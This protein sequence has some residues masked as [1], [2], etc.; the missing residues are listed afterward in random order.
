MCGIIN[1]AIIGGWRRPVNHIGQAWKAA[2]L[3]SRTVA[4]AMMDGWWWMLRVTF[5]HCNIKK[6]IWNEQ[7]YI[8][9]HGN[10][11]RTSREGRSHTPRQTKTHTQIFLHLSLSVDTHCTINRQ[12]YRSPLKTVRA[13]VW[14][15]WYYSTDTGSIIP[16]SV[17]IR[18]SQMSSQ[19]VRDP[20]M[21]IRCSGVRGVV[22]NEPSVRNR[23]GTD[24]QES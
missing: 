9:G 12:R 16:F 7:R 2:C 5:C 24:R 23:L 10:T 14:G 11:V 4:M 18:V 6:K 17:V 1:T 22:N 3:S 15:K 20:Q 8:F 21:I 13:S 19:H